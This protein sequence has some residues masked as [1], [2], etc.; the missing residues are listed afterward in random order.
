MP[1]QAQP[2]ASDGSN[3]SARLD[4]PC[5]ELCT[6]IRLASLHGVKVWFMAYTP[7]ASSATGDKQRSKKHSVRH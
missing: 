6:T 4:S 5:G 1:Y 3:C 7:T 2:Q